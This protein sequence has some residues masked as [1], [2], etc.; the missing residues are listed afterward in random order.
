M[1]V[2]GEEEDWRNSAAVRKFG[3]SLVSD[4]LFVL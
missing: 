4:H 1:E 3:S 2:V